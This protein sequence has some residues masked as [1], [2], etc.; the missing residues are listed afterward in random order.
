MRTIK[1]ISYKFIRKT[2][3]Q[4][5]NGGTTIDLNIYKSLDEVIQEDII[6]Y[7]IEKK[8]LN[9]S[10]DLIQKIKLLLLQDK[11]NL[12]YPL[13]SHYYVVKGL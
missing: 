7:L 6:A 11:P 5:L 13:S 9:L 2:T 3:I 4:T 1:Q 12:T 8:N 10:F